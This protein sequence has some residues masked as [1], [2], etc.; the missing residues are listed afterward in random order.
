[1]AKNII[2]LGR[3][4]VII[5]THKKIDWIMCCFFF[6]L[7]SQSRLFKGNISSLPKVMQR[8]TDS[9]GNLKS[10]LEE[11]LTKY[12]NKFFPTVFVNV[13]IEDVNNNDFVIVLDV[14]VTDVAGSKPNVSI[15]YS[16]TYKGSRLEKLLDKYTG[17]DLLIK[18]T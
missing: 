16:L 12:L 4:A 2:T 17:K 15:G 3:E 9:P 7:H 1:M 11:T 18:Q 6:S 14:D 10:D 8:N 5:D 13:D